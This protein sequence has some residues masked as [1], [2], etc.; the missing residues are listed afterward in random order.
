MAAT[1][2][3]ATTPTQVVFAAGMH[4]DC[5]GGPDPERQDPVQALGRRA[6]IDPAHP[7]AWWFKHRPLGTGRKLDLQG[8]FDSELEIQR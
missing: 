5:T 7:A 1:T 3:N 4:A 8:V 6:A 2:A